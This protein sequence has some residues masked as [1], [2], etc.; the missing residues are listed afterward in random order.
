[1]NFD[2]ERPYAFYG[3]IVLIP[4]VLYTILRYRKILR[5]FITNPEVFSTSASVIRL[6]HCF[7]LRTFFRCMAWIMLVL[8]YAGISWGIKTVPVQK[9]GTTVSFVFDISYSMTAKDGPSGIS[10]LEAECNYARGLLSHLEGTSVSVVL[11]KGSGVTAIPLTEDF[12]SIKNMLSQIHPNLISSEGTDLGSG[13]RAA[14]TSFPPQSAKAGCIWLFTDGEETQESLLDALNESV[15][16]G[17]PVAIIG[18]GSERESELLL[19]DGKTRVKT[20]LRSSKIEET[21]SKVKRIRAGGRTDS[22]LTPVIYV[23]ASEYGSAARLLKMLS[24]QDGSGSVSYEVHLISRKNIFINL[25]IIFFLFSIIAGEIDFRRAIKNFTR[26]TV[27]VLVFCTFTSCSKKFDEG[28]LLFEG[29]LEWNRKN[30][31]QATACFLEVSEMALK[32][33]DV[34]ASEYARFNLA[35]TYLMQDENDSAASYFKQILDEATESTDLQVKFAALYNSGIIS[36]RQGK[37]DEA[38]E[39]FKEA[40]LVDSSSTDAKINLELSIQEK[41]LQVRPDEKEMIPVEKS[42][43]DSALENAVYSIIRENEEKRWKNQQQ[44]TKNSSLDY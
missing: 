5:S 26:G 24:P 12:N 9:S 14:I 43:G 10:R 35:V 30:Y 1:M 44:K 23:D 40:L 18:F 19:A 6:R 34:Q 11:A 13:I 27:A 33:G 39:F 37:F 32:N 38:A 41:S 15:R 31:N 16:Y 4:A 21:V 29:K 20:A 36:H 2:I 42:G 7:F 8:A 28:R 25:A 3:I 22:D 17:I